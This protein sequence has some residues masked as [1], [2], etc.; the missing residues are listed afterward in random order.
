MTWYNNVLLWVE[1]GTCDK[2]GYRAE[3][4]SKERMKSAALF[5][6]LVIIR[7]ERKKNKLI[8]ELPSKEE[9]IWKILS[10]STVCSGD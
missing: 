2:L 3:N 6:F 4:I 1:G 8:T 5:S 7:Q 10:L 9:P